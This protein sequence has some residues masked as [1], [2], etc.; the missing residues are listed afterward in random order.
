MWVE[1]NQLE[2]VKEITGFE[3]GHLP[4]CYLGVTLV[5]IK[6]SAK[7]CKALLEKIKVKLQSWAPKKLRYGGRL[8]LT[9]AV[10]FSIFNYWSRQLVFPKSVIENIEQIS[11]RFLWIRNDTSTIG[12]D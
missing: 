7:D 6:L 3:Q 12:L 9:K 2:E 4:V 10:L 5:T 1:Q 11:T 8:Q